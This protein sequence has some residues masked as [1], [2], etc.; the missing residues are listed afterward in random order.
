MRSVNVCERL[1][2]HPPFTFNLQKNLLTFSLFLKGD[3]G[4]HHAWNTWAFLNSYLPYSCSSIFKQLC[5]RFI[6]PYSWLRSCYSSKLTFLMLS[7][8]VFLLLFWTRS[9]C[10]FQSHS[11]CFK[12]I[13]RVFVAPSSRS[14]CS[15]WSCSCCSKLVAKVLVVSSS[16]QDFCCSKLVAKVLVASSSQ[17]EFLLLQV[18]ILATLFGHVLIA[19][20]PCSCCSK[21]VF[22]CYS[23]RLCSCNSKHVFECCCS[24][25]HSSAPSSHSCY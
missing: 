1:D 17:Q 11:C 16:Q 21:L 10:S 15:S 20:S 8:L 6:C 13:A 24:W 19:P 23:S 9:Y 12:L 3:H 25:L 18:H 14:Y 4:P 5:V 22:K 2:C 7:K